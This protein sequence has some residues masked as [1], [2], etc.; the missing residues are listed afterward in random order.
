[1]TQKQVLKTLRGLT[2]KNM[3]EFG[4]A[5]G[6]PQP[7]ISEYENEKYAITLPKFLEW[8]EKTGKKPEEIFAQLK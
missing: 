1:M 2:G 4:K 8:C 3:T 7:R 5:V 6:M